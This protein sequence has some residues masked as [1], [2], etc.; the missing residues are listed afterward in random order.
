MW[1]TAGVRIDSTLKYA[2]NQ[3]I[4]QFS[5]T[6]RQVETASEFYIAASQ[7]LVS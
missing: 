6:E 7:M 3:I 1:R 2:E 5:Q 4:S